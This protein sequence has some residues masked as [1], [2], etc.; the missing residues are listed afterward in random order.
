MAECIL[1][2]DSISKS[3]GTKQVFSELSFLLR[4]GEVLIVKG[5]NGSGKST[6]LRSLATLI[7]VDSG[8]IRVH[9]VDAVE[10]WRLARQHISFYSLNHRGLWPQMSVL[11]NWK[12]YSRMFGIGA[13]EFSVRV[14]QMPQL[15][16][17]HDLKPHELSIGMR[18]LALVGRTFLLPRAVFIL[19]EPISALDSH[20][21][22]VVSSLIEQASEQ[23]AAVVVSAQTQHGLNLSVPFQ[24]IDMS[25]SWV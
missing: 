16:T 4:A 3:F 2:A 24:F 6:L 10:Q 23:G 25:E 18:Q 14:A 13:K 15:E 11:E 22:H 5:D 20:N 12:V 7:D 17:L 19:D 1:R 8:R 9:R 21:S